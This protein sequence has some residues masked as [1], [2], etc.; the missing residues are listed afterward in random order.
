M[1]YNVMNKQG[2]RLPFLNARKGLPREIAQGSLYE[3]NGGALN[4]LL[5][6]KDFWSALMSLSLPVIQYAGMLQAAGG[7]ALFLPACLGYVITKSLKGYGIK[8]SVP[9]P[10]RDLAELR[11]ESNEL[12]ATCIVGGLHD[13]KG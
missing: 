4:M 6:K 11:E 1:L 2:R 10:N 12:R 9:C 13:Y 7:S 8:F 3:I 5:K